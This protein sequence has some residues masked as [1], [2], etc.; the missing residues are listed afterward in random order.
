MLYII[1]LVSALGLIILMGLFVVVSVIFGA[2]DS[3]FKM[4]PFLLK[5]ALP[6]LVGGLIGL[7]F[8][9]NNPKREAFVSGAVTGFWAEVIFLIIIL[10]ITTAPKLIPEEEITHVTVTKLI[11]SEYGKE[12]II[13]HSESSDDISYVTGIYDEIRKK[14]YTYYTPERVNSKEIGEYYTVELFDDNHNLLSTITFYDYRHVSVKNGWITKYYDLKEYY[15]GVSNELP[16]FKFK[17]LE[18]IHEDKKQAERNA[19]AEAEYQEWKDFLDTLSEGITYEEGK[20]AFTI[21]SARP[22]RE[23]SLGTRIISAETDD[24][25]AVDHQFDNPPWN[26]E[27]NQTWEPGGTYYI[28]LN[29]TIY[30][31][32]FLIFKGEYIEEKFD[33]L[34]LLPSEQQYFPAEES[35]Q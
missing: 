22:D 15:N 34:S 4:I 13:S 17:A 16:S 20:I 33:I 5:Y 23:F 3:I 21:P 9:K 8:R 6:C 32:C 7:L 1:I 31:E 26:D 12:W 35:Y 27:T 19:L 28:E 24:S 14:D 18:K 25:G 29:K 10:N 11:Y 2:I 30:S